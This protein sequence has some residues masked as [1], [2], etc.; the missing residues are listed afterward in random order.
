MTRHSRRN[1]AAA[2]DLIRV[3]TS[4]DHQKGD[5]MEQD[6]VGWIAAIIIGGLAGWLAEK[7]TGSSMGLLANIILG[8]IGAGIAAWLFGQFGIRM[9]AGWLGYL[10]SGFVGACL[11]IL[12]TRFFYPNRFRA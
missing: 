11:L 7:V 4:N 8:V 10:V 6:G 2:C 9:Q 12:V 3:K 1:F 5:D